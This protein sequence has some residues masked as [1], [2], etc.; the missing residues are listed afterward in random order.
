MLWSIYESDPTQKTPEKIMN[1]AFKE[2][3]A[4]VI[5]TSNQYLTSSNIKVVHIKEYGDT[6]KLEH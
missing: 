3:S 6:I 5:N 2:R 1:T 4:H